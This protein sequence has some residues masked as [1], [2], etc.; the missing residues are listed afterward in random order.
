MSWNFLI[1]WCC[2][3]HIWLIVQINTFIASFTIMK[4]SLFVY[5]I[6]ITCL[7]FWTSIGVVHNTKRYIAY[8]FDMKD[9]GEVDVSLELKFLEI[10]I[11]LFYLSFIMMKRCLKD[12]SILIIHLCLHHMIQKIQLVKNHSDSVS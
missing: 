7:F 5:Y 1:K 10:I 2:Q 12:L 9:M 4:V 6:L 3:I 11:A 8:N